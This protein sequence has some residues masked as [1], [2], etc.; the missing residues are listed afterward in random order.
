MLN[1]L[2][3]TQKPTIA[4]PEVAP[5]YL[6]KRGAACY[7]CVSVRTLSNWMRRHIVPFRKIGRVYLFKREELDKALDRYRL[8][9]I[10][11]NWRP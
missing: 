7:C 2:V 1:T 3:P 6:R 11:E 8:N 10:G 4:I 5:G 9:A